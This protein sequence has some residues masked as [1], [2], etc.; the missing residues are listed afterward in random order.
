MISFRFFKFLST[1]RGIEN[2]GEILFRRSNTPSNTTSCLLA[3]CVLRVNHS[4]KIQ[5]KI[6]AATNTVLM[7]IV[8]NIA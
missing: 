3:V 2:L 5:V 1:Q 7:I 6:P 8:S 4:K